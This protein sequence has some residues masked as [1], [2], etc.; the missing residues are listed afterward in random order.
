MSLVGN[1]KDLRLPSLI[2]LNCMERNT[3]KLTIEISGKYGFIYFDGGQV[4]HAEYDPDVGE[5]AVARL[6]TLYAGNFKVESGIRSPITSIKKHWNNLLL[7]C[8]HQ[9]DDSENSPERKYDHLMERLFTVRGVQN[10]FILDEQANVVATSEPDADSENILFAFTRLQSLK[11]GEAVGLEIP[12]F[13]SI[14][15]AGKKYI[16]THY[17]KLD[18]IITMEPKVKL[19]VVLPLIKQAIS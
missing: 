6:L 16:L 4:V 13:V 1:L 17:N 8:L 15:A 3:A 14:A 18:V 2:Q 12:D 11:I 5:A 10:I 19:D 7:D 9:V